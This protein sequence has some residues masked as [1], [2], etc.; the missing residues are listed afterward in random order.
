MYG[1]FKNSRGVVPLFKASITRFIIPGIMLLTCQQRYYREGSRSKEPA[2][3]AW[4]KTIPYLRTLCLNC[5]KRSSRPRKLPA[6]GKF[7]TSGIPY[8]G[9]PP[10]RDSPPLPPSPPGRW[11]SFRVTVSANS[12][13]RKESDG[14]DGG[15]IGDPRSYFYAQQ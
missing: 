12:R 2:F 7:L 10:C 3:L 8:S 5:L 9:T 1:E 11:S 15:I 13:G 14:F 6:W 4:G